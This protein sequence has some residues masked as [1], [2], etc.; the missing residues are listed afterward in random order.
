MNAPVGLKVFSNAEFERLARCGGFG[1]ARVELRR[2]MIAE[3]GPQFASHAR[4]KM[5]LLAALSGAV[6]AA[7]LPWEVWSE[8]S[9]AFAVGFEPMADIVVWDP[10]LAPADLDGPIPAAAVKLIVEVSD[11]T[12]ADDLGD[13][14]EDYAK[15]GLPEYWIADV[16]GRLVLRHAGAGAG[17]YARREPAR[18]GEALG[19]IETPTIIADTASLA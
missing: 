4:V 17:T 2:G 5:K 9:V 7:D 11:T 19:S 1:D 3:M 15:G 10:A 12:L 14:L 6:E 13:K 18:F 8:V 16:R